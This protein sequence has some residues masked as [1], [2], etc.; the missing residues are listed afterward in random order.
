MA[1]VDVGNIKESNRGQLIEVLTLRNILLT[2]W[3]ILGV[4]FGLPLLC[5]G[6]VSLCKSLCESMCGVTGKI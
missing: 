3:G 1:F 2:V 4:A 6:L 5:A